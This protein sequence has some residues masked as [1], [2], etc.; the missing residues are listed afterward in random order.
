VAK[1][2]N[3]G[4]AIEGETDVEGYAFFQDEQ[5]VSAHRRAAALAYEYSQT[6]PL[7][8]AAAAT[9][10]SRLLGSVG[11]DVEVRSGLQ[12]VFGENIAI[13]ARS[14]VNYNLVA[15]DDAPIVIGEDV[16]IGPGVQLI[17]GTH[18]TEATLRRR[19][20]WLARPVNIGNNV[21]VGAGAMILP[22]VTVGDNTVIGASSVVTRSLP[23]DVVAHGNPARVVRSL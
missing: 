11:E 7:D 22:G 20:S 21:W 19:K 6:W 12:V 23:A 10:L 18:P 17:A 3:T 16:K 9:I 4:G 8:R 5:L 13:G 2:V 1:F 14:F 15:L